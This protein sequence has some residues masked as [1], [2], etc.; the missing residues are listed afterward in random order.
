MAAV[1]RRQDSATRV[2]RRQVMAGPVQERHCRRAGSC[3]HVNR[4]GKDR[5]GTR[6][7]VTIVLFFRKGPCALVH[8]QAGN[9]KCAQRMAHCA[10][11]LELQ[12]NFPFSRA[13]VTYG[14]FSCPFPEGQL[15]LHFRPTWQ[16]ARG[17]HG[18]RGCPRPGPLARQSLMPKAT[19]A[20]RSGQVQRAA[21]PVHAAPCPG[22][23]CQ[24]LTG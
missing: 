11:R 21:C 1:R 17:M 19:P 15:T 2:G 20:K 8:V 22:R 7:K 23:P 14:T 9:G 10:T 16:T 18:D 6:R 4:K 24:S 12:K 5:R 3:A 13:V